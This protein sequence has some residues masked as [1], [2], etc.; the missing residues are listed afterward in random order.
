[1]IERET[2][3]SSLKNEK[4]D[5]LKEKEEL[6]QVEKKLKEELLTLKQ[7]SEKEI[8]SSAKSIAFCQTFKSLNAK[9]NSGF[10]VISILV[11]L[12][13]INENSNLIVQSLMIET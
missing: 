13:I 7:S 1:L 10:L 4:E 11:M 2:E 9:L 6:E 12:S 5:L 8:I 3:V